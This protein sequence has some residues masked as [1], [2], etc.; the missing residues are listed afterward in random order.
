MRGFHHKSK[1]SGSERRKFVNDEMR[2][3]PFCIDRFLTYLTFYLQC[4]GIA[5]VGG[6]SNS[7]Q[8]INNGQ[9][10]F[11][12]IS[13][14]K[15]IALGVLNNAE[16]WLNATVLIFH[17][18]SEQKQRHVKPLKCF[19]EGS[20]MHTRVANTQ[21]R[22]R[23]DARKRPLYSYALEPRCTKGCFF[24]RAYFLHV[25]DLASA[26]VGKIRG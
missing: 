5:N 1:S 2:K 18:P 4:M 15:A 14:V 6:I 17:T 23:I 11:E 7:I 10:A 19:R 3:M 13:A 20:G 9:A 12:P 25:V 22:V 24:S 16:I 21:Q 8:H 26:F